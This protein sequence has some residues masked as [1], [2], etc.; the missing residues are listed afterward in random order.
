M[1]KRKIRVEAYS[2]KK[3]TAKLW[4]SS[5]LRMD[6][7]FTSS[8][9]EAID[10]CQIDLYNLSRDSAI[11]LTGAENLYV[12]LFSGYEDEQGEDLMITFSGIVQNVWSRRQPPE[13]ITTLYCL[14]DGATNLEKVAVVSVTK[15]GGTLK[16]VLSSFAK[17]VGFSQGITSV[18]ADGLLSAKIS[19][20]SFS[21]KVKTNLDSLAKEFQFNYRIGKSAIRVTPMLQEGTLEGL[22][23]TTNGILHELE[24]VR[25]KGLPQLGN[26]TAILNYVLTP[27]I[28]GGDVIDLSKFVDPDGV[29]NF[30]SL[31]PDANIYFADDYLEWATLTSYM[32]MS[33]VH[34]GSTYDTQW[35]ST[36]KGMRHSS[37]TVGAE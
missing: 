33:V 30:S 32:V 23:K 37:N 35:T 28:Q 6:F 13:K 16:D 24:L 36:I 15:R 34:K 11:K 27:T 26:Q 18:G 19:S 29:D 17:E 25:T 21:G 1:W 9:H 12:K 14:K 31:Q 3:Y 4:E 10:T 5:S 2:D 8:I 20:R 22:L 7:V